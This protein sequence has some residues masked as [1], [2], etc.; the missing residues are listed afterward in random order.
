[1]K[2][3]KLKK[4][5]RTKSLYPANMPR[6]RREFLDYPKEWLKWLEK[7]H[8]EEYLY[9]AQFTDEWVGGNVHKTG[10]KKRDTG[11]ANDMV[12][13]R[14]MVW[15]NVPGAFSS[16]KGEDFRAVLE[17]TA[18]IADGNADVPQPPNGE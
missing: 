5:V 8:P 14:Y 12:R 2:K 7:N 10:T 15:E 18:R 3:Q 11:R 4:N 1:M 13:P 16:N 9:L 17:E 6:V